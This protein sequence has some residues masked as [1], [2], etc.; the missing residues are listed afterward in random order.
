[1]KEASPEEVLL[2]LREEEDARK[3]LLQRK[4]KLLHE[5]RGFSSEGQ[6]YDAYA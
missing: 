5:T 3:L 2:A 4:D 6:E 1:M